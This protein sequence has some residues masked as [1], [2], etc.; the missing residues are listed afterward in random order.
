[1]FAPPA[2]RFGLPS[3]SASSDADSSTSDG[4]GTGESV[5]PSDAALILP[6]GEEQSRSGGPQGVNVASAAYPHSDGDNSGGG[7][8]SKSH[9]GLVLGLVFGLG[10]G[11]LLAA[12][13]GGVVRHQWVR[14]RRA[15]LMREMG[16]VGPAAGPG[17][18]GYDGASNVVVG[19]GSGASALAAGVGSS[20]WQQ[21]P[22][23]HK[24]VQSGSVS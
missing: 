11:V 3:D 5:A 13:A 7:G 1:V 14:K 6:G 21:P 2:N 9:R 17:S 23:G 10:G 15:F 18:P 16:F 12:I 19:G 20:S 24:L 22:P 4:G 8:G